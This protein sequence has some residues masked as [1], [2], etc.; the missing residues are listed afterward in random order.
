MAEGHEGK[1]GMGMG[2]PSPEEVASGEGAQ[3]RKFWIFLLEM[4]R[5]GVFHTIFNCSDH[6]MPIAWSD[7]IEV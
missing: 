5:F 3:R 1:L 2:I 6:Q 7:I 4:L